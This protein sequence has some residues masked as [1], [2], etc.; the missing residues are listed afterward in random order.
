MHF[1]IVFKEF[2]KFFYFNYSTIKN[3]FTLKIKNIVDAQYV[4]NG[5]KIL[6]ATIEG[7]VSLIDA[8]SFL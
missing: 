4:L 7:I 5:S 3:Y 8:Y 6:I 2:V 1:V